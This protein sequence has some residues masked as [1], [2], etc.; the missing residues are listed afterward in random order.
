MTKARTR[1]SDR[2]VWSRRSFVLASAAVLGIRVASAQPAPSTPAPADAATTTGYPGRPLRLLVGFAA[3]GGADAIARV[4][5][6][7]LGEQLGQNVVVDNRPGA[8][9]TIAA[10]LL[11]KSPPDGYS[12]MLAD[13]SL[14]IASRAMARSS[15]DVAT[16]FAPVGGAGIAPLAIC[17]PADSP[18]QSLED[19]A[20]AARRE[21]GRL[22]YATSGIGT[23]HHLAMEVLQSQAKITLTH[24]PYRGASQIVPDLISGQVPVAV[25][26]VG[27]AVGQV[28]AKRIRALGLT[29]PVRLPGADWRFVADWL[30]GFDASP[31]L[32]VL[33]PAGTPAAILDRL[34]REIRAALA[35]PAV[36]DSMQKQGAVPWPVD[37]R[38]LGTALPRELETWTEQIRRANVELK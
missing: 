37:R 7:R 10:D 12:L 28:A 25:L 32:F 36:A 21:Q 38:A 16:A 20:E 27:A 14:L 8:S 31:R 23:V 34:D 9:S 3:G 24:L 22:V 26:S 13:S 17:V 18:L 1:T 19:L 15:L 29:S 33:A 11:A 30:P 6:Q 2:I 35:D 5:G 4:L